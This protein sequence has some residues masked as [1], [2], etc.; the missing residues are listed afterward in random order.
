M[1][2]G[3]SFYDT[4]VLLYLLSADPKADKAESLLDKGGVISVQVLNEFASVAHRKLKMTWS[5]IRDI[6]ATFQSVCEVVPVTVEIHELGLNLAERYGLSVYDGFIV[7]AAVE[8]K[9]RVV[10]SEDMQDGQVLHDVTIRNP[11]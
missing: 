4:N 3:K 7:A 9:C 10:Y 1:L 2:V 11:F 6:L 8:A 5:E